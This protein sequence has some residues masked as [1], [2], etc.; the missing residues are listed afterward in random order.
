MKVRKGFGFLAMAQHEPKAKEHNEIV[1]EK[2]ERITQFNNRDEMGLPTRP[3]R[4]TGY[5]EEKYTNIKNH[6]LGVMYKTK[7]NQWAGDIREKMMAADAFNCGHVPVNDIR[8]ILNK[9][10]ER[11]HV[12]NADERVDN[13]LKR[14]GDGIHHDTDLIIKYSLDV[15]LITLKKHISGEQLRAQKNRIEKEK[16]TNRSQHYWLYKDEDAEEAR[17]KALTKVTPYNCPGFEAQPFNG[18]VCKICH[19]DRSLHTMIHSKSD[20]EAI[21]T[22]KNMNAMNSN[23]QLQEA[24]EI[25]ARQEEVKKKL[26]EQMNALGGAKNDWED[27]RS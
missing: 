3:A 1:E 23:L 12:H 6:Q 2:I 5:T 9:V 14:S 10:F 26:R 11:E 22:K 8:R 20:Y 24:N 27:V 13:V 25:M 7:I 17:N 21:L 18:R 4:Y 15:M 19:Y 16:A